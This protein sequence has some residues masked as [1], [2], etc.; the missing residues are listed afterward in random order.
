MPKKRHEIDIDLR[1]QRVTMEYFC[2]GP[3]PSVGMMG[4]DFED[5]T[6]TDADGNA[7]N[8]ELTDAE[9]EMVGGKI[10]KAAREE[11]SDSFTDY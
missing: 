7:L 5:E 1:G 4:Y 9:R 6:F 11:A 10:D 3:D 8:W 2:V